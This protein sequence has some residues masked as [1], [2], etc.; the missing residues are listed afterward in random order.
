MLAFD[1]RRY[2][3]RVFPTH[4]PAASELFYAGFEIF[5]LRDPTQV[6]VGGME[7]GPASK[8]GVHWGDVLISVNEVPVAGKTPSELEQMFS[9][10]RP[11][12]MHL[13]VDRLGSVKTFEFPIETAAEIARK[14]GNRFVDSHLVPI[15]AT[16]QDLHCFLK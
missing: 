2:V 9:D 16:D 4:Y 10:T 5:V 8:A 6:T 3:A 1:G 12:R 13:Q 11:V 15:W 14:N 7:E